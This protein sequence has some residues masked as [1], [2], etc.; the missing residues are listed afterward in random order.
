M[1][2]NPSEHNSNGLIIPI[3]NNPLF[4]GNN[5]FGFFNSH[6][7]GQMPP[8]NAIQIPHYLSM[9]LENSHDIVVWRPWKTNMSYDMKHIKTH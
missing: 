5:I 6:V 7:V 4:E 8:R 3:T 2:E 1:L 9:G